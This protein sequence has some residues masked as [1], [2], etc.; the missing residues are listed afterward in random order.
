M[1]TLFENEEIAK[2]KKK[3]N[4]YHN[5]NGKFS[6]RFVARAELAE[7]RAAI[8]ENKLYYI[9]S[10]YKGAGSQLRKANER[11]IELEKMLKKQS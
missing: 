6:N 4:P 3:G 8:A 2:P 1:A 9:M 11:I 7:K 5:S 10:V